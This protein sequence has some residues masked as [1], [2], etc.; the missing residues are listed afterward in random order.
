MAKFDLGDRFGDMLKDVSDSNTVS[1]QQIDINLLDSDERNFYALDGIDELAANIEL[2]GLQQP[3]RVRLNPEMPGRYFIVS[4]HRRRAAIWKLYEEQPEKWGT[5]PCIV[6]RDDVSPAMQE[7]RLIYANSDTRK[8]KDADLAKQAERVTE[9]LYQLKEEGV[10][11]PGRM[12]DHVAEACKVSATKL[13]TLKVIQEK[14]ENPF[15]EQFQSGIM[16]TQTAY[17]LA[18]LPMEMQWALGEKLKGAIPYGHAAEQAVQRYDEFEASTAICPD[19]GKCHNLGGRILA[20][21]K[22]TN[23]VKC[24]SG[25]DCCCTCYNRFCCQGCC[26][27]AKKEIKENKQKQ[28]ENDKRLLQK[29]EKE[30]KEKNVI[31]RAKTVESAKRLLKAA[32]AAGL[33]DDCVLFTKYSHQKF[34]VNKLRKDA[35]DD[36]PEN[37]CFYGNEYDN[38]HSDQ[39]IELS[40]L[41][42]CSADYLLGL[43]D[44]LQPAVAAAPGTPEW[45][46]GEPTARGWYCIKLN[47]GAGKVFPKAAFYDNF[48]KT[49][50]FGASGGTID[51]EYVLGWCQIPEV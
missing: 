19:M 23:Y 35:S 38:L 43:T 15:A 42:H 4:G 12:R 10:E 34:D 37:A 47:T 51:D 21:C 48:G 45:Q 13:A 7:L 39:L 49:W 36:Y 33:D 26:D 29:Q 30:R 24:N 40:G 25:N 6:E 2:V 31:Y 11:F 20:I 8:M 5:V 41:L 27:V 44:E 32:D 16:P 14:L 50:M 28:V 3:I 46:T 1:L 9:L 22:P 18:R 17:A